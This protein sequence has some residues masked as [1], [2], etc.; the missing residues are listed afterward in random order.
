MLIQIAPFACLLRIRL[1]SLCR[2]RS[3]CA[4][5][6]CVDVELLERSEATS[7]TLRSSFSYRD[8]GGCVSETRTSETRIDVQESRDDESTATKLRKERLPSSL[9]SS[10]RG[11]GMGYRRGC[12]LTR[13]Y[14]DDF[15]RQRGSNKPKLFASLF[16]LLSD[17]N[18]CNFTP[19]STA[20]ALKID[21]RRH[22]SDII[23]GTNRKPVFDKIEPTVSSAST[24]KTLPSTR[25]ATSCLFP[26]IVCIL[27]LISGFSS[28]KYFLI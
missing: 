22:R 9:S 19:F 7:A 13:V 1:L 18:L 10:T 24:P 16:D 4:K 11:W 8:F 2:K 14:D 5:K 28:G 12:R 20:P 6:L 17:I 25:R 3:G 15:G 23:D 26:V 27:F 21:R